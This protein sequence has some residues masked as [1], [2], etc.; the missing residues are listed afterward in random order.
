LSHS[1]RALFERYR[2]QGDSI[3]REEL[4]ERFLPLARALA[5]RYRSA[6]EPHEDLFQ[7]ACLGLLK[8][9]DRFDPVQGAS[10][11]AYAV[12]TIL[13]E[14]KR[15]FRDRVMPLHMPRGVKERALEVGRV[16]ERLTG[17]LERVPNVHEV[18]QRADMS[19][20][21]VVE[22]LGAIEASRT[23]SLDVPVRGED[24]ESPSV[25]EAVG[26]R[27]PKLDSIE[28]RVAVSAA[29]EVL[30]ERERRCVELRFGRDLTQEEI[31]AEIG[32]SQVHVSR[33]LRRALEKMRACATELDYELVA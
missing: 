1:E 26:G 28:S 18:A 29:M 9:I 10:F 25:V 23:I 21:D 3:A 6:T 24:G 4:A 32:V 22:A 15:H 11:Q 14:L 12:P 30:D 16:S 13:G 20:D 7:V 31:A 17:E 2:W 8:A 27:D 5:R 33:I 19:E